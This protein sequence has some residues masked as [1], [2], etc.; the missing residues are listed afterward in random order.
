MRSRGAGGNE[1]ETNVS[2]ETYRAVQV[3]KPHTLELVERKVTEPP[4]GKV[5]IRVEACGVCHTDSFTVEGG[6]PGIAYPRVPGHEVVGKIDALGE[7]V[8]GWKLGQRVGVGFLGGQCARCESCRRGDFVTCP[9]QLLTGISDD[10]GYA[11]VMFADERGLSAIPDEMAS[12]DAGPLLCAGVTT[13]N[14]LRNSP[15]RPGDLVAIQGIGGLGHLGVQ[16]ARGMGFRVAAIA[17]GAEKAPLAREL[18]AHHYIDNVRRRQGDP[19]HGVRQQVHVPLDR[20]ARAQGP[21]D[22]RGRR[23]GPDRGSASATPVRLSLLGR[24]PDG[25][26]DRQ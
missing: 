3:S 16:F 5:R 26:R 17:R 25:I 15:A 1:T 22:R 13:F 2:T 7:G 12:A 10:G 14:A 6:F 20:R 24:R 18:G 8:S 4:A 11:E 9:N 21:H 19:G 23:F